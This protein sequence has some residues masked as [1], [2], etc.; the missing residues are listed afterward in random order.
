MEFEDYL[1]PEVAIAA[2]VAAVVFS[3][4]GRQLLRRGAVYGLAGILVAGDSI[5]SLARGAGQGF[6]AAGTSAAHLTS[7]AVQKA[8][9]G[10]AE[11]SNGGHP[12][13]EQA[14]AAEQTQQ[15]MEGQG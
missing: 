12:S 13:A 4:K 5:A 14:Q 15:P 9:A 2:T 6:K 3:P 10:A 11:A 7:S 1:E 8:K